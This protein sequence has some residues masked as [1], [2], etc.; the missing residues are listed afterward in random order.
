MKNQ[1]EAKS[2][3]EKHISEEDSRQDIIGEHDRK[4][5]GGN[6]IENETVKRRSRSPTQGEKDTEYSETR[7][8][9]KIRRIA[10]RSCAI[11]KQATIE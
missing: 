8:S 10:K 4:K 6:I 5:E 7:K 1:E 3:E 11:A 9:T 2:S